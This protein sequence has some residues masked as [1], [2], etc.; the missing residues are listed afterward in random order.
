[1]DTKICT[2]CGIEKDIILFHKDNT[3]KDGLSPSCKEC[4]IIQQK[5]FRSSER[6][7]DTYLKNKICT[8]CKEN[9]E[10]SNFSKDKTR[11]DG[12][13]VRCKSCSK[14]K[15]VVY[16]QNN[17]EKILEYERSPDRIKSK[18]EN[19]KK[20]YAN[21]PSYDSNRKK[22]LYKTDIQFKLKTRYRGRINDAFKGKVKDF[23]TLDLLGCSIPEFK[24][25]IES[26]FLPTMTWDNYGDYWHLDHILPCDSFDMIDIDHVKKCF[27][28]TNHQPLFAVTQVIEGITYIGN[29]NKGSKLLDSITIDS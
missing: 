3:K 15:S 2:K 4:K 20:M 19:L 5:K 10:V 14:I 16:K 8:C 6:C 17:R 29:I 9:K 7:I 27:H 21:N 18:K 1:M 24:T 12:L 22:H 28:Y 25:Y 26:K 13:N 11:G 23:H